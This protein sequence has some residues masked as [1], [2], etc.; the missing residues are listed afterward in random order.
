M[1]L[2]S[3]ARSKPAGRALVAKLVVLSM[4]LT[5]CARRAQAAD[6]PRLGG[7]GGTWISSETNLARNW[8]PE[9][10]S[11]LWTVPVGEGFGG[12]AVRDGEVYLLDRS[13]D[14]DVLRC[15]TL[16]SGKEL[17]T[18]PYDAP[19]S[20]PYNGSRNVPT[21]D[22][23]FVFAVGPFGQMHCLDRK[24]HTLVWRRHLVE[25]FKDP[26][27]DTEG[28]PRNREEALARAQVPMWGLT[29]APLLYRDTVIV[30]P[31]THRIGLVAYDKQTGKICWTSGYIGRNWY[32]HV[33]PY[34]TT[35]CGVE[36]VIMLAQPSDP[37]K[38]PQDAPPAIISS[39]DPLTGQILWTNQ[40]PAP[41]KIPIS[42]PLALGKDRLFIT[43]AYGFG[44]MVLQVRRAG[45]KWET[46]LLSHTRAVAAHIQS[47]VFYRNRIYVTSFKEHRATHTGL[48]CL[49]ENAVPI[50]QTGPELQFDSGAYLIAG[51]LL[52]ILHGRT[53]ELSLFDLADDGPHLLAKAQVLEA[54]E[55]KA[56]APLALSNGKLIVRD[57]H[58]MKCLRVR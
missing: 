8:P 16:D 19:G 58:E 1:G 13:H 52:F 40:T 29:Q 31:Q 34:L 26:D 48:V 18:F 5:C 38:A 12:A 37:E 49:D 15:L 53:G 50:W 46:E 45:G 23:N 41:D 39:V 9:G 14:Q 17:W 42:E 4:L 54:K 24:R 57:Q 32:S 6:W 20:L 55:G 30:A 43:G 10:P 44:C 27:M 47:P 25:D 56:W 51:G 22:N 33:S 7:P 28:A 36:Q 21:V 11:V 2:E 3:V 35:L